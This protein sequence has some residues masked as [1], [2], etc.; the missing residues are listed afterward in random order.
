MYTY[1]LQKYVCMY[2]YYQLITRDNAYNQ[3]IFSNRIFAY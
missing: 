2:V 3:E 1:T